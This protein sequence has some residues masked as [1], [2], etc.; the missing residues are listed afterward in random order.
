MTAY[1]GFLGVILSPLKCAFDFTKIVTEVLIAMK[2]RSMGL[3]MT[4]KKVSKAAT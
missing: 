2:T 3:K 4:P 1:E